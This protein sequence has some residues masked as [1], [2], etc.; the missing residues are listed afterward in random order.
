MVSIGGPAAAKVVRANIHPIK[1]ATGAKAR[2]VVADL[3]K[4]L[5]GTPPPWLARAMGREAA[6][7]RSVPRG[8]RAMIAEADIDTIASVVAKEGPGGRP[9]LRPC[10]SAGPSTNSPSAPTTTSAL[11]GRCARPTASTFISSPA[12]AVCISFT[13]SPESATGLV[14]AEIEEWDS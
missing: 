10:A 14:I 2:D 13:S 6:S 9:P 7:P 4:V 11:P 8:G 12:M 1:H 5:A 3:Q